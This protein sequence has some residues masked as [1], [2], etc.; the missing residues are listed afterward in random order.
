MNLTNIMLNK[1]KCTICK[2]K[3]NTKFIYAVLN[4][5]YTYPG[6]CIDWKEYSEALP[7][8]KQ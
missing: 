2:V 4:Q 6:G 7:G 3:A 8:C 5:D 1:S